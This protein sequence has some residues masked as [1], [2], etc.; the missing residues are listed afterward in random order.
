MDQS[1]VSGIGNIYASEILFFSKIN[2]NKKVSLL[3]E[4]DFKKIINFSR[5]VLLNAIKEGGSTIRDF[6]NSY[7][8]KGN[9]QKKFKVYEREGL[10]CKRLKCYGKIQK[11]NI[12]MRSTY[13]CNICQ[14]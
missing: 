11:K 3:K 7:G 2:P 12:S 8:E 13:Y 6:R 10:S 5:K 14:K 1:F 4:K 9:F